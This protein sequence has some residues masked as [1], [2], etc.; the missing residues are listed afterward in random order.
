MTGTS[1]DGLDVCAL[2]A[3]GRGLAA[4]FAV[5][6]FL[7]KPLGPVGDQLRSL[8]SGQAMTAGEISRLGLAFGELHAVAIAECAEQAGRPDLVAVHGQTV[9]HAP[10]ASWQFINPWPIARRLGCPIVSDLR[11]ADLSAGG[12]GAPIT[13]LAD[14]LLFRSAIEDRAVINLGGFCNVTLLPRASGI[15]AV[16]GLDVCA[17]N[18]VLDAAARAA[19]GLDFDPSGENAAKGIPHATARDSLVGVLTGQ[20]KGGRSLGTGDESTAW[21]A[22]WSTELSSAQLLATAVDAVAQAIA[23]SVRGSGRL[24][25]A[26]GGAMNLTLVSAIAR[27]ADADAARSDQYGIAVTHREAAEMG[28]LGLLAMDGEPITLPQVTG[29][30]GAAP[31][32]GSWINRP[33]ATA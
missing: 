23:S 26:G 19:L 18:H 17:C 6:A 7:S 10:P 5:K 16:R 13:P 2:E 33:G 11:G 32:A 24:I 25:V 28:V 3:A 4:S 21:V 9:F 31:I 27:H 15:D 30:G 29:R 22:R 20:S 14:W 1:L 8:A 12:Q